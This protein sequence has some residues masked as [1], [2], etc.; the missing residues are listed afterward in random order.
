MARNETQNTHE[1]RMRR[2][3]ELMLK[4]AEK[5]GVSVK[6]HRPKKDFDEW[7]DR[8]ETATSSGKIGFTVLVDGSMVIQ[9]DARTE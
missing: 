3:Y 7:L 9:V 5:D 8:I 4:L 6:K 2:C 1:A